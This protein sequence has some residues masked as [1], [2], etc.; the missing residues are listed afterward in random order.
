VGRTSRVV[1]APRDG[2]PPGHRHALATDAAIPAPGGAEH[3]GNVLAL[4]VLLAQ[5]HT[6]GLPLSMA[7][8]PAEGTVPG[9]APRFTA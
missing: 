6:H 9:P 4:T 5:K 8:W 3:P 2:Y 1:P 7:E